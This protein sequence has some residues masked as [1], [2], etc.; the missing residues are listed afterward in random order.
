[1]NRKVNSE[2][3]CPQWSAMAGFIAV[4]LSVV[5]IATVIFYFSNWTFADLGH[6]L[7]DLVGI[8]GSWALVHFNT[9]VF[10]TVI[11]VVVVLL[12]YLWRCSLG[13][14]QWKHSYSL[15]GKHMMTCVL[16]GHQKVKR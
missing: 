5:L 10:P 13:L 11:G 16:C 9:V 2:P 7:L 6:E 14:H 12:V 4:C 3:L 1:M 8:A 15:Q